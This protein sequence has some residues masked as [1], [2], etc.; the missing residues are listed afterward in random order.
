M[1]KQNLEESPPGIS[2]T[3]FPTVKWGF[4]GLCVTKGESFST[5]TP[6]RTEC[7]WT[8]QTIPL[9]ILLRGGRG[10]KIIKIALRN[11]WMIPPSKDYN[12]PVIRLTGFGFAI[13]IIQCIKGIQSRSNCKC[14]CSC[15][16]FNSTSHNW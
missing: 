16:S 6:F 13:P 14:F 8:S 4:V 3:L 7:L 5:I 15:L 9:P 10:L 1:W 12:L 11:M 2:S